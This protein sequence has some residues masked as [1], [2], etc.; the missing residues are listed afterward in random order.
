MR[1]NILTLLVG[2]VVMLGSV[3]LFKLGLDK[4]TDAEAASSD[5]YAQV[6]VDMNRRAILYRVQS[7]DTLWSLAERFYGSGRRW[8]EIARANDLTS[9]EGLAAGSIIKIPLAGESESEAT[10]PEQELPTTSYD[11]VQEAVT[12]GR[13]GL[14]DET[15]DVAMCRMN[16][17]EFPSGALCVARNSE[18]QTVRLSLFNAEEGSDLSPLAV[19]EAPHG[20]FLRELLSEDLDGDGAQEIYTI[21]QTELDDCTS[22]VLKWNNGRLEVVSETPDDPLA[23]IRLRNRQ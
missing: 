10:A 9:G 14:D 7:G 17:A 15:I 3:M 21:W 12:A 6:N 22:R 4:M 11:E 13:F 8:N 5:A 19:Y 18:Q 16:Q 23:L 2:F 1:N 20:N